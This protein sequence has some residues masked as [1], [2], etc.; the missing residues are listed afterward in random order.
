MTLRLHYHPLSSFCWKV[1]IALYEKGLEFEPVIV[2]LSDPKVRAA[3]RRISPIAKMPALEDTGRG[4]AV[5]ETSAV[6][7]YL[8]LHHPGAVRLVPADADQAWRTRLLDRVFDLHVNEPMGKVV[9]DK[10][11]PEGSNDPFGVETA[12]GQLRA[13]YAWLEGELEGRTWAMGKAFTL[14][15]CAAAPGLFYADK[16]EPFSG[17][18][19]VLAAYLQR[20]Q[21][22]PSVARVLKEAEPYFAMF[23]G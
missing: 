4:V 21:A 14:A 9:T 23:P 20:L 16:V 1:L 2:D 22:R 19:P 7:D 15:D 10:L 3:F 11:R 5:F 13:A 18:H 6:I 17:D 8:D 12:R